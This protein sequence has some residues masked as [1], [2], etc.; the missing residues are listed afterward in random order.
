MG[1]TPHAN[2]CMRVPYLNI[3]PSMAIPTEKAK[4]VKFINIRIKGKK[5]IVNR[6]K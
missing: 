2:A 1:T 6:L 3:N 5:P 4:K